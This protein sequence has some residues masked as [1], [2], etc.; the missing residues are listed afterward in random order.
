MQ[1][2]GWTVFPICDLDSPIDLL[3]LRVRDG[4]KE[5]VGIRVKAHGHIY[6]REQDALIALGKKLRIAISHVHETHLKGLTFVV[7]VSAKPKNEK[8]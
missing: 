7:V 8:L 6:Q 3:C 4:E 5:T 1:S 2:K